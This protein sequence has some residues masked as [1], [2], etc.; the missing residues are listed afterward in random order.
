MFDIRLNIIL[1]FLDALPNT[2]RIY[3]KGS[4]TFNKRLTSLGRVYIYT[5]GQF[6]L[7]RFE[8]SKGIIFLRSY[9]SITS[10]KFAFK[11]IFLLKKIHFIMLLDVIQNEI[12]N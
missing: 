5:F 2:G 6:F 4:E 11:T 8:L 9:Q 3:G 10:P 12:A 7:P 1:S